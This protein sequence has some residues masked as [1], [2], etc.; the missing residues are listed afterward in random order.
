MQIADRQNWSLAEA[1]TKVSSTELLLWK[2]YIEWDTNAFHREDYYLAQIAAEVRRA[3]G[4]KK[5]KKVKV[6]DLLLKF[7]TGK[8]K[9]ESVGTRTTKSKMFWLGIVGSQGMAIEK[10]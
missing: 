9:A 5:A 10:E 7:T 4:G 2:A 3:F 6:D 1:Q 8:P